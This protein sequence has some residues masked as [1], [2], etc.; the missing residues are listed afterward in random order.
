MKKPRKVD[1]DTFLTE[2]RH[3]WLL[4]GMVCGNVGILFLKT[5]GWWPVAAYLALCILPAIFLGKWQEK[6]VVTRHFFSENP[7]KGEIR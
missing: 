3:I 6:K 7:S 5:H 1:L 2:I 4:T